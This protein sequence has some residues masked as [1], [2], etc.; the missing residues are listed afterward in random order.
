MPLGFGRAGP[1]SWVGIACRQGTRYGTPAAA[2]V[3]STRLGKHCV[4]LGN[5]ASAGCS[6]LGR[7][8]SG[9][10][11]KLNAEVMSPTVLFRQALM[12]G[13]GTLNRLEMV[14]CDIDLRRRHQ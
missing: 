5:A 13:T 10:M 4:S 2:A 3:P 14:L 11:A 1:D 7:E 8:G 6:R 9:G 12:L